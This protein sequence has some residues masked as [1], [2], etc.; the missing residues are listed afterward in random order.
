MVVMG[1]WNMCLLATGCGAA[2]SVMSSMQRWPEAVPTAVMWQ[3]SGQARLEHW[4]E[5]ERVSVLATWELEEKK[6]WNRSVP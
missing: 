4:H 3:L 5:E 2:T 1:E 6:R